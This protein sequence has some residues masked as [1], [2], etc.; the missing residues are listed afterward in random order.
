MVDLNKMAQEFAHGSKSDVTPVECHCFAR[1][2]ASAA[3]DGFHAYATEH[4][5]YSYGQCL[6]RY[7]REICGYGNVTFVTSEV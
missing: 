2:V 3:L 6:E 5:E 1:Q 7:K 4:L